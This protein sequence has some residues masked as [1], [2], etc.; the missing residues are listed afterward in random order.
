[1]AQRMDMAR[2]GY[3]RSAGKLVGKC[4]KFLV[5]TLISNPYPTITAGKQGSGLGS[6]DEPTAA[7]RPILATAL[8]E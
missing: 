2:P 7:P 8:Q 4:A 1:M 6:Y 5:H 3:T